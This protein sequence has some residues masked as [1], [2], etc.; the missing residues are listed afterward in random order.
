MPTPYKE[1]ES[2]KPHPALRHPE[3]NLRG[4]QQPPALASSDSELA[5]SG[6][7]LAA[8]Q[9]FPERCL[10]FFLEGVGRGGVDLISVAQKSCLLI[11]RHPGVPAPYKRRKIQVNPTP[12]PGR[13]DSYAPQPDLG[14]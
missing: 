13:E 1:T 11:R 7:L 4:R 2:S 14:Y 8:A 12:P 10:I 3:K 9:I 5:Q 6:R